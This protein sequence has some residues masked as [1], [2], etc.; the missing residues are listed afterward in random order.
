MFKKVDSTEYKRML[1]IKNMNLREKV[2][3]AEANLD[4]ISMMSGVDMPAGDS[5]EEALNQEEGEG[6]E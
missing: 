4:Y 6:N 1:E 3:N 2:L 5:N